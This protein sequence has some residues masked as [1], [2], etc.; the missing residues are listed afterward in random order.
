M[1]LNARDLFLAM[2]GRTRQLWA[3]HLVGLEL[4]QDEKQRLIS[5]VEVLIGAFPEQVSS[6]GTLAFTRG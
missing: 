3:E 2:I 4:S 6:T 1:A 5:S